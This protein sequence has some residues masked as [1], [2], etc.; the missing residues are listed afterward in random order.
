MIM[1]LFA[2]ATAFLVVN[3]GQAALAQEREPRPPTI[4]VSANGSV[5]FVPDVAR[6]QIGVRAQASSASAA[7]SSANA[8]AA[9]VIAAIERQGISD[10]SI[11]TS[12]FNLEYREPQNSQPQGAAAMAAATQESAGYYVA[13]EM[14]QV[15]TPVASAGPV[16]DAAI[17]A[18]ANTSYGLTYQS[19]RADA[20]Y[21]TALARAVESARTTAQAIAT[22]AHVRIVSLLSL[23]NTQEQ[24]GPQPMARMMAAPAPILPGTDTVTATVYAVYEVK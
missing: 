7:V 15:T 5:D 24:G 11:S 23:S 6:M 12:G 13:S 19:S 16:L 8:T 4:S 1:K 17:G 20:L 22:A 3:A 18:G 21:R 9:K 10:R 2:I 14:L